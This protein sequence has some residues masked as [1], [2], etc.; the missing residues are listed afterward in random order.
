MKEQLTKPVG[1][2]EPK[3]VVIILENKQIDQFN[4]K[5]NDQINWL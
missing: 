1:Q 5:I 3:Q 4:G 2:I